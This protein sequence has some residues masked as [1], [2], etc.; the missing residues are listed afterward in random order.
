MFCPVRCFGG[1]FL[2]LRSPHWERLSLLL[3][4]RLK[5]CDLYTVYHGLFSRPLGVIGRLYVIVA[6]P[7]LLL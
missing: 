2:K 1:P 7:G 3:C 5:V 4:F 6:L